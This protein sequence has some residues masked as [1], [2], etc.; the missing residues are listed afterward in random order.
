MRYRDIMD[1]DAEIW[2]KTDSQ[3]LW[4]ASLDYFRECGFDI[5][6][7]TEDLHG[8]YSGENFMTEHEKRFTEEGIPIR[9]LK[10]V[11]K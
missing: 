11:K 7:I 8:E 9:F 6:Y 2:F 10:A 4:D 3:T 5:T 1:D